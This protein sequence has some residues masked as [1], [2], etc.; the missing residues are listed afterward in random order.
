MREKRAPDTAPVPL[1]R[2]T[3]PDERDPLEASVRCGWRES[4]KRSSASIGAGA[5]FRGKPI[6]PLDAPEQSKRSSRRPASRD[7]CPSRA[8]TPETRAGVIVFH[9]TN[10]P[11]RG[12]VGWLDPAADLNP[13]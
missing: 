12:R 7:C 1:R 9:E 4:S 10:R 6:T 5:P 2:D 11:S 3:A 8:I 13:M